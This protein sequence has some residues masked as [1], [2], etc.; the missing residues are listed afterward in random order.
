MCQ[1]NKISVVINTY[2]E[3]KSLA[4]ILEYVKDFDEVLVCD[5]ES[6]DKTVEIARKYGCNIVSFPK[7][8]C[9]IVEPARDFAIH[10]AKYQWVLV[11]DADEII[12]AALKKYL[13]EYIKDDG[14]GD[15]LL[16]P[17]KN[18]VMNKYV[19]NS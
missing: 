18:Y 10:S 13:Y 16:I 12:P 19:E 7:D 1:N 3:E 11:V 6:S 9:S 5:M 15:A 17:R 2:N 4:E 8:G 14:C